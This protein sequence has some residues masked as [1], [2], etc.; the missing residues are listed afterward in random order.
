MRVLSTIVAASL[1]ILACGGATDEEGVKDVSGQ[2]TAGGDK[3][4]KFEYLS[5][6]FEPPS[7][8]VVLFGLETCEGK[9]K[10]GVKAEQFGVGK[11]RAP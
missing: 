10:P 3:C 8:I 2:E 11:M 9:P 4:L 5:G 7:N 1:F 6:H